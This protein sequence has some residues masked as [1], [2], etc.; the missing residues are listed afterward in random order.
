MKVS[1]RTG[2]QTRT[3]TVSAIDLAGSEDNRRT[4][5][6]KERLVES[7]SINKSLFVLAQCV[8]AISKKQARI[9]YRESKMTRILCLGQNNALT[10]MILNLA[11]VR[12]YHLDTLSSLN[13]ANRTKKIEI[14]EIENEPVFNCAPKQTSV[15]GSSLQ[16][17]QPLRPLAVSH[18][19]QSTAT[20]K[21]VK[22]FSVYSDNGKMNRSSVT[23]ANSSRK[24]ETL[25]RA[26]MESCS[27]ETSTRLAKAIRPSNTS[28]APL[29]GSQLLSKANIEAIIDRRI[30]EQMA[31]QHTQNQATLVKEMDEEFQR[32]LEKLERRIEEK[33]E[34]DDPKAEGLQYLLMA[35]QHV[36]AGHDPSALKM[37]QLA[38]PFFPE[39]RKLKHKIQKLE[40]KLKAK[41]AAQNDPLLEA[42]ESSF[43]L[44]S[45]PAEAIQACE[46]SGTKK[47]IKHSTEDE[48]LLDKDYEATLKASGDDSDSD[49]S[50]QVRSKAQKRTS[51]PKF[52]VFRDLQASS[53]PP[54][55]S[56]EHQNGPLSPRTSTLLHIINSRDLKQIRSL[57]GVGAKRA[58]AIVD[59]LYEM[60]LEVVSEEETRGGGITSLE[61]LGALKGVGRSTVEGM[62]MGLAA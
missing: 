11:P 16:Q 52:P 37:Y 14:N 53:V 27:S 32:R 47:A 7:A 15:A 25:K 61:Q 8:E 44:P 46:K 49:S 45:Q 24:L 51:K 18:N 62:R 4:E 5:N 28:R 19:V 13:F 35:K 38:L 33:E 9:P 30:E 31:A 20:N 39:N 26:A 57:K 36:V 6:G 29:L 3:S 42:Q 40:D 59:A 10:V 23:V 43:S 34:K 60:D 48:N 56:V 41:K 22:E 54:G 12:S 21:P 1:Q 55:T 50:F 58:G 17:R 2:D